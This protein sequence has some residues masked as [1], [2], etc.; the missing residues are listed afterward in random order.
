MNI[1]GN[2]NTKFRATTIIK[3]NNNL[4]SKEEIKT[5]T[6]MGEKIGTRSDKINFSVNTLNND[7]VT[8]S[9]N[10]KFNSAENSFETYHMVNLK[11]DEANPFEY[12][13]KKLKSIK[14]LYKNSM[15]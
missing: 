1:H 7:R 9:H 6:K 4:L 15:S 5:L 14:D 11:K 10:A 8:I 3:S 2:N 12:I 13:S